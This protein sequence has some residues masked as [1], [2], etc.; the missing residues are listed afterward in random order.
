MKKALL[1]V[2]AV[3]WVISVST[4]RADD[5]EY[6]S[7]RQAMQKLGPMVGTWNTVWKFYDKD[8]VTEELG[9][10]RIASVLEGTYLELV[11]DRH[12]KD[13]PQRHREMITFITFDP[14]TGHYDTTDFYSRWALRVTETGNFDDSTREFRTQAFIPKEDGI[15][16]EK[17]RTITTIMDPER[18]V[19][20]HY[21]RY[22]NETVERRDLE[23]VL[24]RAR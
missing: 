21:S 17:V 5:A 20:T 9:T 7:I 2:A 13:N 10:T 18:M 24:T 6:R 1:R 8:G 14:R 16:D 22:D 23:I 3:L 12:N 11:V 4:A 19:H 15:H